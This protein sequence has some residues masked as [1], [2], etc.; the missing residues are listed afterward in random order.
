MAK[1]SSSP[2]KGVSP[3]LQANTTPRGGLP[4]VPLHLLFILLV[5]LAAYANTFNSPFIFDDE[6]SILDNRVI[7]DLSAFLSGT[8]YAYNPRRFIGYLSFALNYKLAGFQ[9]VGYHVVNLA[10]H[11]I[12]GW[13]VYALGCL[14]LR[15]PFFLRQGPVS[16]E[17]ASGLTSPFLPLLAALLFVVHPVQTQ[18]VTYIVQRLASLATLFY[19]G[20]ILLYVRGRLIQERHGR[21]CQ[22]KVLVYFCLALVAGLAAMK[23]KEIAFTLPLAAILYDFSFFGKGLKKRYILFIAAA[24]TLVV[25]GA[26]I[27]HSDKP[28]G[29]LI[30]DISRITRDSE[31]SRL[32]YLFTQFTV[33]VTYIRLLFIPV[34][35]N[36]DYDYPK[37]DSMLNSQVF[38]SFLFLLV[39]F[40]TALYFYYRSRRD[41][42]PG[43]GDLTT[44]VTSTRSPLPGY[45]RLMAF[46]ILWFFLTL[47]IESSIIP[48]T[49]VIFEHRL[50]LPSIGAFLA[51][52]AGMSLLMRKTALSTRVAVAAVLV[53]ILGAATFHRNSIWSDS[54]S[55]WRDTAAKS[56]GKARPHIN[57]GK[58]LLLAGEADEA[59]VETKYAVKLAPENPEALN[60]LGTVYKKKGMLTEAITAYRLALCYK[61]GFIAALGN[62]GAAL[63]Q[64]GLLDEAIDSYRQALRINSENMVAHSNLGGVLLKKGRI[65]EAMKEL[66]EAIRM[67]PAAIQP[68]NNLAVAYERSG[69][70]DKAIATY[71]E[72]L[73]RNP[74]YAEGYNNLGIAYYRKQDLES[75]I[76]NYNEAVRL[77]PTFTK[78]YVNRGIAY[79][80]RKEFD[81]ALEQFQQA[82]RVSPG[83]KESATLVARTVELKKMQME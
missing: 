39:L 1:K 67:E 63:E 66:R 46:G 72:I 24:V 43:T 80:V 51:I 48:I 70:L 55:L 16:D 29:E 49:D 76:R 9:L 37:Y 68:R 10:I 33:I 78:A 27:F 12:N 36:L 40:S 38:F 71:N 57:L 45:Y 30:S 18:A 11:I 75:A 61:P 56:P 74:E 20:A 15:T 65:E 22:P 79:A 52:A 41:R 17:P 69:D 73:T 23:T 25:A 13:L 50:Y 42:A 54:L 21:S 14:T 44:S 47:A 19:L 64:Q 5:A 28:L 34:G 58:L 31:M 53:L 82:Q 4:K 81:K 2:K 8:G 60:N 6:A 7:K 83:D 32:D 35:Q 62:L 3:Q 77:D 26:G 59:L